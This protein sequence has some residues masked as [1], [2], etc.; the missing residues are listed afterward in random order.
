M[1]LRRLEE[2]FTM[3]EKRRIGGSINILLA[4]IL[5]CGSAQLAIGQKP[6][7]KAKAKTT[8]PKIQILPP[9]FWK[10]PAT[11]LTWT[12]KDNGADV[13][14]SQVREYCSN[15]RLGGF[16]DWRVPTI[17]ELEG[18]YDSKSKKQYKTK[19]PIQLDG[20][21]VWSSSSTP[22]QEVWVLYFNYGGRSPQRTSGHSS[23]GRILCVRSGE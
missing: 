21:C 7:S 2:R 10:D 13:G 15:V 11:G 3:F 16:S 22:S 1:I 14:Y 12:G 19:E 9:E 18:I 20:Q 4:A 8:A 17:D 5:L 23:Y 6:A